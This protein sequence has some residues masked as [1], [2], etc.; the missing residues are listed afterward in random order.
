MRARLIISWSSEPDDLD[1]PIWV[2]VQVKAMQRTVRKSLPGT[3]RASMITS[4]HNVGIVFLTPSGEK[5]AVRL[6]SELPL[7]GLKSDCVSLL[8][9]DLNCDLQGDGLGKE[10]ER[11][12]Q[13]IPRKSA[14]SLCKELTPLTPEFY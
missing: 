7:A 8:K 3:Y 4:H 14:F 6:R 11:L 5:I 2:P 1:S 10:L 9:P 13:V 12:L